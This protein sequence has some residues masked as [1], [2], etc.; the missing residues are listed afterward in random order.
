MTRFSGSRYLL[1]VT[2]NLETTIDTVDEELRARYKKQDLVGLVLMLG[3]LSQ[4]V[5]IKAPS[6]EQLRR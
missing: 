4:N 1:I 2:P 3:V 5:S 6:F